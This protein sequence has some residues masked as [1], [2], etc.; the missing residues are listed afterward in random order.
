MFE[1]KKRPLFVTTTVLV[2]FLLGCSIK[3]FEKKDLNNSFN[4]ETI[5]IK[6]YDLN[7]DGVLDKKEVEI[8]NKEVRSSETKTLDPLIVML[9]IF[10]V[11]AVFFTIPALIKRA[12]RKNN[13]SRKEDQI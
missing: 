6:E 3:S 7:K 8:Y 9:Q 4:R 2:L 10:G 13:D 1:G 11:M 12:K 5:E